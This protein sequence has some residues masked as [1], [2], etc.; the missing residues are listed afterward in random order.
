MFT[1]ILLYSDQAVYRRNFNCN[2]A[3]L[4]IGRI[5][6]SIWCIWCSQ[7]SK[8][9]GKKHTYLSHFLNPLPMA[10]FLALSNSGLLHNS[11]GIWAQ[12]QLPLCIQ[13]PAHRE[14]KC[15]STARLNTPRGTKWA[16][17]HFCRQTVP[18][19]IFW[20][21]A[22]YLQSPV[23]RLCLS[24]PSQTAQTPK[25]S[26]ILFVCMCVCVCVCVCVW[27]PTATRHTYG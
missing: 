9:G 13:T 2:S 6:C 26:F 25:D 24:W 23:P 3:S 8:R 14:R 7:V 5:K 10:L 22:V 16:C 27:G 20:R 4:I 17:V 11:A 12:L 15:K 19:D 21:R 1:G 18:P